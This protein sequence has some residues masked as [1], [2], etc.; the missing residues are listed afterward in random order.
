LENTGG[1]VSIILAQY[2]TDSWRIGEGIVASGHN[3]EIYD[4]V[5]GTDRVIVDSNGNV[6]IGTTSPAVKLHVQG[7]IRLFDDSTYGLALAGSV[8]P[9]WNLYRAGGDLRLWRSP[10]D[11]VTFTDD[12]NVGIREANPT[13]ILSVV[14]GSSTDP[15]ADGWT[16]YSS[17]RWKTNIAPIENP[18]AIVQSLRGVSFDWTMNDEHDIGLI[19]EEVGQVLPEIVEYEEN[20]ID[21]RS[22]DYGRLVP[23]LIEATKEQQESIESLQQEN[24]ELKTEIAE[25]RALLE[26]NAN[27]APALPSFNPAN[28]GILLLGVAGVWLLGNRRKK[29]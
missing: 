24:A 22:V 28:V 17:G 1:T 23:V 29:E 11:V 6:G 7:P 10:V 4:A 18:V 3:F 25:I 2:N 21:A 13:N 12:F 27:L 20:G 15:I 26:G 8:G 19:A 5:A 14:Q 9:D 16:T